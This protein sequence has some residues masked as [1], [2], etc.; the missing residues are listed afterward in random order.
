MQ[1]VDVTSCRYIS[2]K[3]LLLIGCSNTFK[4]HDFSWAFGPNIFI[5]MYVKEDLG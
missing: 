3:V 5:L 4:S 2:L 1:V